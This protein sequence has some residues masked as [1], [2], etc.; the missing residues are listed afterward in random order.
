MGNERK[1][2]ES[3]SQCYDRSNIMMLFLDL[4][5]VT[6]PNQMLMKQSSNNCL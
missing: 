2:W 4:D 5:G 3:K 6:T 1:D